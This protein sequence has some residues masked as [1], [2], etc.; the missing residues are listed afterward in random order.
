MIVSTPIW[1][2]LLLNLGAF[3]FGAFLGRVS[4]MPGTRYE[5]MLFASILFA[6]LSSGFWLLAEGIASLAKV[7]L[8]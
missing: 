1:M 4:H 7:G 8:I 6:V 3:V 2:A 5:K